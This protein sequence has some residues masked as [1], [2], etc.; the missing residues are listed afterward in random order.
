MFFA[1][2]CRV[3]VARF[4]YGQGGDFFFGRAVEDK[5]LSIGRDSVDQAAPVR[6]SDQ[7]ALGIE[8]HHPDMSFVALEKDRM[9]AFWGD[10]K[11]LAV[12]ACR[13]VE[14]AGIVEDETPNVFGAGLEI[15]G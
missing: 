15:D 1:D 11:Y 6:T 10:A 8:S 3:D 5:A 7:I 12:I 4:I 2:A 9:L 13:D 14:A